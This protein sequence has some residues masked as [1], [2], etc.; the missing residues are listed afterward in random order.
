MTVA[1]K[2]VFSCTATLD[3]SKAKVCCAVNE[4][5]V[6]GFLC[7]MQAQTE[8]TPLISMDDVSITKEIGRGSYG[9]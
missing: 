8:L 4:K 9:Y 3:P 5:S 2:A 6:W 7:G 1:V